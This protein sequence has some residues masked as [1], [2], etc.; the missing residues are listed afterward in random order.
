MNKWITWAW[1]ILLNVIW[2]DE[3]F[4][5]YSSPFLQPTI[6]MLSQRRS[7]FCLFFFLISESTGD[8]NIDFPT[9]PFPGFFIH[10]TLTIQKPFF[11]C[12]E[13][14]ASKWFI[15]RI[16]KLINAQKKIIF[17]S[18][19]MIQEQMQ[20]QKRMQR[21]TNI[22]RRLLIRTHWHFKQLNE[23]NENFL[24]QMNGYALVASL[25]LLALDGILI[26]LFFFLS[27]LFC[28]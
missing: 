11:Y 5:F 28:T 3:S 7:Q 25:K 17:I 2:F 4:E 10:P 16:C 21:C 14:K 24:T 13:L 26:I 9:K 27:L 19:W 20:K 6:S 1:S 8:L 23:T 15:S 18:I 22:H 12:A